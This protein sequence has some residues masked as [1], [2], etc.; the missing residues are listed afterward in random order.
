MEA[1]WG[2]REA[3]SLGRAVPGMT[4]RLVDI[5]LDVLT[6]AGSLE[7]STEFES[8]LNV[9]A[10][11]NSYGK[12][13]LLQGIVFALGLEGMLSR[14]TA[15]P[16]GPIMTTVADLPGGQRAGVVESSVT[17][18]CQNGKGSYL[19]MR[20]FATS[21]DVRTALIQ[22]WAAPSLEGLSSAPQVDTFVRQ[23]G[24]AVRELGFHRVLAEFLGWSLPQ[25]PTYGPNEVPLYLEALFPL[26]YVEQ[27][28]GW[29][30]VTPR[31]PTYLGIRD[32]LRRS[33]EYVLGLSTLERLRMLNALREELT[34]IRAGW[35]RIV[36]RMQSDSGAKSLRVTVS[37]TATG[38]AQRR[39]TMVE[40]DLE[41]SW[42]PLETA[43]SRWRGRLEAMG[44]ARVTTAGE[45]TQL[46][47][48]ELADAERVVRRLGGQLRTFTE[49]TSY[50]QADLDALVSRLS[51]VE[52]DRRRLQ[53][54]Q[55]VRALGSE[56]GV[57]L[58]SQDTCPTC[59]QTLDDRHVSTGHAATLEETLVL[60]D[61][62]RT[63]LVDM[64]SVAERRLTDLSRARDAIS[65]QLDHA[66]GQVRLLRDELVSESA[67][68][69]L[70]EVREQL[71]L[72]DQI[73][74]AQRVAA[75]VAA[76]DEGLDELAERYDDVR[77]KIREL[78]AEPVS[79]QDNQLLAAFNSSF[80]EQLIQY[81]LSSLP[82]SQVS[83]DP[84]S[85]IPT[86]DGI[87]L[88]FDIAYGMSASDTIRTKW[89]YY[90]SLLQT[91]T[92]SPTGH[93]PGLLIFD[94]P[95]QQQTAKIS[96]AAL[97]RELGKASQGGNQILYATSEDPTDLEGF[98]RGIPH[99]RL[100][101]EGRHLLSLRP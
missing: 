41:G 5:S 30:G 55:K 10:A 24:A 4:L 66:R 28:S 3:D 46:S 79:A 63:T 60:G 89:A 47:R 94:E 35:V 92:Q 96:L 13:T 70:V 48:R 12:S 54:V 76:A 62:E 69:S 97:V 52:A 83:I 100:L 56:L 68:P 9:L 15:A 82:P 98:L 34:D 39:P 49:Q 73:E 90:I 87:E 67:A 88:R 42:T 38:K 61:A 18:T 44:S 32:M 43:V 27:K 37:P 85:L 101:T 2:S 53:D 19:R 74:S 51:T 57:A 81:G 58:L 14:S 59:L 50:V 16:L 36:D 11:P 20:R 22:T 33:V 23:G 21:S 72:R 91:A 25:V 29:A 6:I 77:S 99:A 17:L 7:Y 86:D 45:R 78:E 71:W 95:A 65:Q 31:M 64:R 93:H 8:G 80:S 26:F 1:P 40:A 84:D 75:T